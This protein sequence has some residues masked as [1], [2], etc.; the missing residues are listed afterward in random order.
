MIKRRRKIWSNIVISIE[1]Y[2]F[3]IEFGYENLNNMP[4]D[5]YERHIIWRY[6]YIDKDIELYPKKDRKIIEKYLEYVRY[7]GVLKKDMYVEGIYKLPL[8][9][10]IDYEKT[11][12]VDEALA[13]SKAATPKEKRKINFMKKKKPE[14]IIEIEE[15]ETFNNQILNWNNKK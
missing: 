14:D 9:N 5:S 2:Q 7:N 8:K 4:F 6:Q 1:N 11:L 15:N 3:K 10:I 13:Q 12:T